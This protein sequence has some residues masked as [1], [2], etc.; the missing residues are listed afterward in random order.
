[1]R[2]C[3]VKQCIYECM[4]AQL[5]KYISYQTTHSIGN[6]LEFL[7]NLPQFQ[8]L[9]TVLQQN[10]GMLQALLQQIGQSN[11]QLLQVSLKNF[12]MTEIY[13]VHL[14]SFP[15]GSWGRGCTLS[16]SQTLVHGQK[17]WGQGYTMSRSHTLLR[18]VS[19]AGETP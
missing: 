5:H 1:M 4:Y 13:N 10:P 15:W 17:S 19:E 2:S 9:R 16:H 11:P 14:A 18:L 12:H 3:S 8:M 7:R 6:P